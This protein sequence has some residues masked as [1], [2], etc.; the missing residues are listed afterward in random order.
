MVDNIQWEYHIEVLGSVFK[1]PKPE[2]IAASLNEIGEAGWEVVNLH[3]PTNSNKIWVT[4][5]RPLR[6]SA[7]RQRSRSEDMW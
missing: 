3:Q 2:L 6:V 4:M 7:R 5:K 1:G